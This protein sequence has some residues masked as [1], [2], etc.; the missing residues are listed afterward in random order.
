MISEFQG[1]IEATVFVAVRVWQWI[2]A[3]LD[4]LQSQ[5]AMH[6]IEARNNCKPFR[7]AFANCVE[8]IPSNDR[9][10]MGGISN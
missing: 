5:K 2:P 3:T 4:I 9:I 1:G 7:G 6:C 10:W 8:I